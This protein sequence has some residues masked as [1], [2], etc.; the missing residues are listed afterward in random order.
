MGRKSE[1]CFSKKTGTPLTAFDNEI[2]AQ[3]GADYAN[4]QYGHDLAPYKCDK[5]GLW[6]LSPKDRHTPSKTCNYCTDRNGRPKELYRSQK[7]AVTRAKIIL[8]ESG[9][10]LNA[11]EC[12]QYIGWHLTKG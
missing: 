6:H 2:E 12:H 7:D 8:Q 11:Y 4:F 10:Y 9:I 3:Q 1:T 5:C